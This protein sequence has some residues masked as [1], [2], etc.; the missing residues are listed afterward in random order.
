MLNLIM[1]EEVLNINRKLE[2]C[3]SKSCPLSIFHPQ[4]LVKTIRKLHN[5]V[6]LVDILT[7]VTNLVV[8]RK[9]EIIQVPAPTHTLTAELYL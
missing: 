8:K 7:E 6:H 1:S 9:G 4:V 2:H 5:R 3:F